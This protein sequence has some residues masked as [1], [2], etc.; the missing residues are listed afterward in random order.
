MGRIHGQDRYFCTLCS[1]VNDEETEVGIESVQL[2]TSEIQLSSLCQA[3]T[4]LN[5]VETNLPPASQPEM[6]SRGPL[7]FNNALGYVNKIKVG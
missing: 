3:A 1:N 6:T 4:E 5:S 2:S 7:E